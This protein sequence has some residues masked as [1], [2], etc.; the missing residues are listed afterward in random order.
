MVENLHGAPSTMTLG[1]KRE[2]WMR[3][4]VNKTRRKAGRDSDII[5]KQSETAMTS[6]LPSPPI[7]RR[8]LNPER[9]DKWG[10]PRGLVTPARG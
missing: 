2:K 1:R 5:G 10:T 4:V 8:A 3:V 9:V 6:W 7:L